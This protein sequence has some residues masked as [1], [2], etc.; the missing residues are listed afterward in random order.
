MDFQQQSFELH[1]ADSRIRPARKWRR[2]VASFQS[3][4]GVDWAADLVFIEPAFGDGLGLGI[5]LHHLLAVRAQV[6]E[7]GRS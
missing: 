6:A 5:E 3:D 4:G 1:D 7:L 2:P